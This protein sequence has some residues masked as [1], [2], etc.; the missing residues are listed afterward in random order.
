ME[1]RDLYTSSSVTTVVKQKAEMGEAR[2]SD[3]GHE[4]RIQNS[5]RRNPCEMSTW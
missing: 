1:H 4:E 5:D 3:R 2:G